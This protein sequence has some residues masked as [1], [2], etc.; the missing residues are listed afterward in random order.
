[1][2][3]RP[4]FS[5][6][7]NLPQWL[8]ESLPFIYAGGGILTLLRTDHWIGAGSGVLLVVTGV[9]VFWLRR[10]M[11]SMP[12]IA[13]SDTETALLGMSWLRAFE[14][15]HPAL[16]AEHRRLFEES[17]ALLAAV[18]SGTEVRQQIGVLATAIRTHF[19]SEDEV[20]LQEN[21]PG[22]KAHR[23][24]HQRLMERLEKLVAGCDKGKVKRSE[25]IHF[26]LNEVVRMHMLERDTEIVGSG[27]SQRPAPVPAG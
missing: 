18:L 5:L 19:S 10:R 17:Q 3:E 22:A 9:H 27:R 14:I 24:E 23:R 26:L 1:M 6:S 25:L 20:L 8:Y 2:P 4:E 13:R 21:T 11:R 15:E 12:R 16:D 7:G